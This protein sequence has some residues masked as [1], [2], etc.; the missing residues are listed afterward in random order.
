MLTLKT[1]KKLE[2]EL[3]PGLG[4][5]KSE[6][7]VREYFETTEALTCSYE[8]FEIRDKDGNALDEPLLSMVVIDESNHVKVDQTFYTDEYEGTLL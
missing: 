7:E 5:V 8:T 4:E 2:F 6:F 3:V 1:G